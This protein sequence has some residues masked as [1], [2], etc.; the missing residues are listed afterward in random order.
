MTYYWAVF[1]DETGHGEFG[2]G[3][4][5]E[6]REE[7]YA[8]LSDMY[9]ECR[10][11]QLESPEDRLERERALREEVERDIADERGDYWDPDDWE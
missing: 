10:M 3:V 6:T 9:C 5:A 7:A 4:E 11:V 2:A 8:E 1:V